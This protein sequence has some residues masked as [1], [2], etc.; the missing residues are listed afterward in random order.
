MYTSPC[1]FIFDLGELQQR[2]CTDGFLISAHE[3]I[4]ICGINVHFEGH[5]F[6]GTYMA[7][8]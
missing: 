6:V 7:V 3:L 1:G 8:A 4:G 5:I 2:I